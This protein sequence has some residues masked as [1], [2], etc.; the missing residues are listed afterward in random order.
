MCIRDRLPAQQRLDE[1]SWYQ[2]TADAVYQNLDIIR[3]HDPRFVLILAGDHIYKMDYGPMLAQP[4]E[5][6]ADVTIGCV[7][8]SKERAHEFGVLTLNDKDEVTSL[9]EKP[10]E[11]ETLPRRNNISLYS[12][13]IY[14]FSTCLLYTSRCV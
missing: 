13:G 4:V 7:E 14:W 9:V 10:Q 11:P 3:G 6:Q 1:E 12:I 8:V 2:G 5:H